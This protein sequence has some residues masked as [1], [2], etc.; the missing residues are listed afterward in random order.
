MAQVSSADIRYWIGFERGLQE[1]IEWGKYL[2]ERVSRYKACFRLKWGVV[3]PLHPSYSYDPNDPEKTVSGIPAVFPVDDAM[4]LSIP[5]NV[6][7]QTSMEVFRAKMGNRVVELTEKMG[8]PGPYEISV[9]FPQLTETPGK[10][11]LFSI[12]E[13]QWSQFKTQFKEFSAQFR[14]LEITN[15]LDLEPEAEKFV[16][17]RLNAMIG[18]L[19][20]NR[21]IVILPIVP[22]LGKA[23]NVAE[24]NRILKSVKFRDTTSGFNPMKRQ[25]PNTKLQ[26][27]KLGECLSVWDLKNADPDLTN[28]EI[29]RQVF[30]KDYSEWSEPEA[31]TRRVQRSFVRAEEYIQGKFRQIR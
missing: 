28:L 19:D 7:A 3:Y 10:H 11:E 17:Q 31:L 5:L 20:I 23:A 1:H 4:D 14:E 29:A 26:I 8:D 24:F 15:F 13:K 22:Q 2:Q 21:Q 18:F 27:K 30:D 6:L 16:L 9:Y 12:N 25:L